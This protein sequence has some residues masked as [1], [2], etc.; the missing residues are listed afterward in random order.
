VQNAFEKWGKPGVLRDSAL[1]DKN[2]NNS[3]KLLI[4]KCYLKRCV[5]KRYGVV[6]RE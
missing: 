6:S 4:R 3:E 5:Q 1:Q 2:G